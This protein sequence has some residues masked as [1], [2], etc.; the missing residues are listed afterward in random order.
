MDKKKTEKKVQSK[1]D[2]FNEIKK[3]SKRANETTSHQMDIFLDQNL[4]DEDIDV[5]FDS[6]IFKDTANPD[7]SHK[8]YYG[9]QRLLRDYLPK[10][11]DNKKLRQFVYDEKNLFLNRGIEKNEFG[12]RG[13]DSRMT[14]I[15]N[16]LEIG[17]NTVAKWIASGA[18]SFDI[19]SDF[20][21]LNEDRGYHKEEQPKGDFDNVVGAMLKVPPPPKD[22]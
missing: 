11:I 21:Q 8:L 22:K 16:F 6:S 18:N 12:V 4:G 10:G 1:E 17:F 19:Y 14:Y 2:I 5:G 3:L 7:K 20:W 15:N 13:S 9:I